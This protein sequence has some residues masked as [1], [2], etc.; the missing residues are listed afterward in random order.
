MITRSANFNGAAAQNV[1]W[2]PKIT[3]VLLPL[4]PNTE[5]K[6]IWRMRTTAGAELS[7][8]KTPPYSETEYPVVLTRMLRKP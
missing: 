1:N 8:A 6:V 5:L 3:L 7:R 2:Y 4:Q